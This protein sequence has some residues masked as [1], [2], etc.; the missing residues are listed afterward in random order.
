MNERRIHQLFEV[1]IILKGLDALMECAGGLLLYFVPTD[2][3]IRWVDLLTHQELLKNP[4][5]LIANTLLNAAHH[6]SVGT[7]SFYAFYLLSHGLIKVFLVAGLL[8][9]V[10]WAYPAFIV[11]LIVFIAYQL[12]RYTYAPSLGLIALSAFD[13]FVLVLVWH[14]WHILRDHLRKGKERSR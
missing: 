9:D 4:R 3:I 1:S 5:D 8:K 13:L 12:Y 7:Q 11:A 6:F 2:Q 10:L 14:E